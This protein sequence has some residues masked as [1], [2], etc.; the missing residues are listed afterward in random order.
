MV[1]NNSNT[2]KQNYS[3]NNNTYNT[4]PVSQNNPNNQNN[5]NAELFSTSALAPYA[6]LISTDTYDA[7]TQKALSGFKV[8]KSTLADGS[9]QITLNAQNPEYKTQTYVVKTGEKLYFIEKSLGDD[10]GDKDAFLGDDT[11]VLVDGNGYIVTQ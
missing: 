1:Y 10:R 3:N 4:P 7:N 8:V 5:A 6:Y 2:S 9:V 11:A